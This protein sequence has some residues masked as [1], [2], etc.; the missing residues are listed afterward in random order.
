M[1]YGQEWIEDNIGHLENH[2]DLIM[3]EQEAL[4]EGEW[5]NAKEEYI[6]LTDIDE[7]YLNNIIEFAYRNEIINYKEKAILKKYRKIFL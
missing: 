1:G 5:I 4:A 6:K 2:L 3:S 7:G